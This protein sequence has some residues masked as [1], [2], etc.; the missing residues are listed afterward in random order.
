[1]SLI[2][3]VMGTPSLKL[4]YRAIACL[5]DFCRELVEDEEDAKEVLAPYSRHLLEMLY[6]LITKNLTEP[7]TAM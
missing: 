7:F 1:M 3:N 6:S 5:V 2:T 4:Q